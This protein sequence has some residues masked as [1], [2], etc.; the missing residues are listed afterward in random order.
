MN[1]TKYIVG[2]LLVYI[3]DRYAEGSSSI[4]VD[5]I[6]GLSDL[7]VVLE[8]KRDIYPTQAAVRPQIL[9]YHASTECRLKDADNQLLYRM[10]QYF[11]VPLSLC[12]KNPTT[13]CDRI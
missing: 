8:T 10:G 6:A 1:P 12:L 4:P 3:H 9:L 2:V 7:I 5:S 13:P 11:R